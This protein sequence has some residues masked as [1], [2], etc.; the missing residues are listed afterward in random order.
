MTVQEIANKL[1]QYCREGAYDKCYQELYSPNAKSIEPNQENGWDTVQGMEAFAEKGKQWNAGIEEFYGGTVSDPVVADDYFTLSMGMDYKD[2]KSG[3][4]INHSE[5]CV[6]KVENGK[7]V[8]EQ[9]F[10]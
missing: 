6:Y 3:E 4:R 8:S 7:I 10:Y 1:V 2:K 9:F 5:I